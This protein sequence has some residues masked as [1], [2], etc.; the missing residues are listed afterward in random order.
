MRVAIA[1]P[2]SD[3]VIFPLRPA[4]YPT[5]RFGLVLALRVMHE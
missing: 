3:L 1:R 4:L 2:P 5:A